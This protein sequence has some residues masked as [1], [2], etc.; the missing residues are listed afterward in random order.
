MAKRLILSVLLAGVAI[1]TALAVW[2]LRD[3]GGGSTRAE[4]GTVEMGI[5]PEVTGN[6]AST[7]GTLEYCVRVDIPSPAFDNVSDYDIDV[8][9]RG[10]TQAPEAYD[11]YV[12]YD[13]SKVHIAAPGTNTLVKLPG[14]STIGDPVPDADGEFVAAV[15]YLSGGP[16]TAGDGT[17]LRL[18]LDIGASGLVTFDFEAHADSTTYFSLSGEEPIRH[19]IARMTALLAIN[20]DC[21]PGERP[22]PSPT[23]EEE[24]A[25]PFTPYPDKPVQAAGRYRWANISIERPEGGDIYV[26]RGRDNP[27]VFRDDPS[28][29]THSDEG[30]GTSLPVIK[31]S[32]FE[33][34]GGGQIWIDASTGEV[35]VDSVSSD[36]SAF[37][38]IL[39][40]LRFEGADAP[41]DVW[42]YSDSAE[43]GPRREL[44][45]DEHTTVVYFEP[46]PAAGMVFT[47]WWGDLDGGGTTWWLQLSSARWTRCIDTAGKVILDEGRQSLDRLDPAD[48]EAFDRFISSIEFKTE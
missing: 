48:A 5:D 38:A 23:P 34:D 8:Y 18:G 42:P 4:A 33:D 1:A 17:L 32:R 44:Q 24:D 13:A 31:L 36:R 12:T 2:V 10:D 19:P 6:T 16:G 39:A 11:A 26:G 35:V 14:A 46:D 43:R 45:M 22:Q 28:V 27:S 47:P 7:L 21:P 40:T 9:V 37:D 30:W 25:V 41:T 15:A 20:E 29:Y 3:D